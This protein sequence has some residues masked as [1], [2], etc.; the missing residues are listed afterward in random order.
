[1]RQREIV[2]LVAEGPS[3]KD[4]AE[5]LNLSVKTVEYHKSRLMEQLGFRST[6]ELT[7]YAITEGIISL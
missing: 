4:I 5:R 6:A 1:M 2:E 3:L 7:K